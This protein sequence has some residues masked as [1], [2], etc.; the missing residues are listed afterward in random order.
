GAKNRR[1]AIIGILGIISLLVL[2]GIIFL[3]GNNNSQPPTTD[4]TATAT[5]G[6]V[7]ILPSDTSAPMTPTETL[8]PTPQ[9]TSTETPTVDVLTA[10]AQI[11]ATNTALVPVNLTATAGAWTA[12]PTADLTGTIDAIMSGRTA[13]LVVTESIATNIAQKATDQFFIDQTA[14]L[15]AVDSIA[16]QAIID[17]LATQVA[18]DAIATQ[19]ALDQTATAT[20]WTPTPTFTPTLTS[21]PTP[22]FTPTPTATLTVT[23]TPIAPD[24]ILGRVINL[25][26]GVLNMRQAPSIEDDVVA[27]AP[28]DTVLILTGRDEL[29]QWVF[30]TYPTTDGFLSGWVT[31]EFLAI[32]DA[33]NNPVIVADVLPVSNK[34]A[35]IVQEGETPFAI[36]TSYGI[37]LESV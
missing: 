12:T 26:S 18:L 3:I 30:G 31:V 28:N 13:T 36:A 6:E 5:V 35:H 37:S 16:Q 27:V 32:T 22:T 10:I 34:I 23:P 11:D 25:G 7:V 1:G 20:L 14:T 4:I 2:A 9:P 24:A 21:T 33:M 15:R 19:I 29:S 17:Q 8:S